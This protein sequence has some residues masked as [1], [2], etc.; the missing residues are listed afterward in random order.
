MLQP[1]A[2][3]LPVTGVAWLNTAQPAAQ[4]RGGNVRF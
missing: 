4:Q 3:T 1:V 2:S